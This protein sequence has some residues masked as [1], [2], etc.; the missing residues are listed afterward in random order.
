MPK[1][2]PGS[3]NMQKKI[4]STT[5]TERAIR[6]REIFEQLQ[7]LNKDVPVVVE[8]KKDGAALRS[9]G[10]MGDILILHN[11]RNIYD[12]CDDVASKYDRVVLLVDW[13]GKGEELNS[14]LS[15]NLRGL[16]EEFSSYRE[17]I[18]ILCQKEIK[19]IEGIPALLRRLEG[20]EI[21]RQ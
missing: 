2:R 9:L 8:G 20:N 21:S 7:E 3:Q 17:I 10:I 15:H 16:F 14:I 11:G 4:P 13:D 6:L 12:F 18:R 1:T 5:D 19:D